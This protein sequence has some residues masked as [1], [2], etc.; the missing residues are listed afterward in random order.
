MTVHYLKRGKPDTER[1]EDDAKTKAIVESTLKQIEDF[2]DTAVRSLSEKFDSY[3]PAS[4]KLSE[5][6]I[7]ALIASLTRA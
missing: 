1:A 3:S 4:F 5:D 2:G 6:E 7:A